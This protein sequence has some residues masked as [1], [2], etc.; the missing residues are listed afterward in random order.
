MSLTL[1]ASTSKILLRLILVNGDCRAG[2]EPYAKYPELMWTSNHTSSLHNSRSLG[3]S[4]SFSSCMVFLGIK[5]MIGYAQR[6]NS[7]DIAL[8][9]PYHRPLALIDASCEQLTRHT[10][11][12]FKKCYFFLDE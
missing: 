6:A 9:I 3:S 7:S 11:V 1:S 4:S 2:S 10:I 12:E 8:Q 5:G